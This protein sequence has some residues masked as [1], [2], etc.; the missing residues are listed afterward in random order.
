MRKSLMNLLFLLFVTPLQAMPALVDGQW[1]EAHGDDAR[2]VVLDI[3]AP[4]NFRRFHLPRSVNA[5][6]EQWRTKGQKTPAGMLPPIEYLE[7]LL[8]SLGIGNQSRVLIVPTGLSAGE[9][10]AAARVYW[11]FKAL[12]HDEVGVLDGGLAAYADRYGIARL[13][14]DNWLPKPA[15]YKA[16]PD[17]SLLVGVSEVQQA[18]ASKASL[19][20]AR[21]AGEYMG[22]HVGGEKERPGTL[23]G[24]RNLPFDW[25]TENGS[26]QLLPLA[27]QRKLFDA[28]GIQQSGEQIHFCHTGSRAAL[29][30]FVAYGVLGNREAKLYDGSMA[31]WAPRGDLPLERK[32]NL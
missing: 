13:K 22:L 21:S 28:L 30:W 6:Y 16:K 32:L 24:A 2:L 23:P 25:L 20:D 19:V 29:S 15:V 10:A 5:S 12:G 9:M 27:S 3:Q 7:E 11:T 4:A 14:P 31:E 17:P 8:G 1:V 26:G 18:L